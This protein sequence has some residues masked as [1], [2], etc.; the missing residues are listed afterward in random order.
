MDLGHGYRL[1][2]P[3]GR[4]KAL[5]M[6]YDDGSEHDRRLVALFNAHGLCGSFHL[7]STALGS[8][9]RVGR[10]E[11]ARLYAGHEIAAHGATHVDLTRL[12]DPEVRQELITDRDDLAALAGGPVRGL[13]YPFGAYD[14]RIRRL[15]GEAGFI[16]ARTAADSGDFALPAD[17]L[18]LAATCH[19]GD[20]ERFGRALVAADAGGTLRWMRV[21]GHS[22][23]LDG[24]M[25]ADRSKDWGYMDSFC[26]MMAEAPGIWHAPLAAVIAYLDAAQAVT[27]AGRDGGGHAIVNRS[28]L[29]LWVVPPGGGPA[30]RVPAGTRLPSPGAPIR[31]GGADG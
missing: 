8:P 24:F 21:R 16:Y 18:A 23:E 25:T 1:T 11:V 10:D 5:S 17:A 12:T 6:S 14:A 15:A 31:L 20:A 2:F 26:R 22:F 30:A 27:G 19:H 4:T 3:E 28:P 29:A 7:T 9:H 13:A